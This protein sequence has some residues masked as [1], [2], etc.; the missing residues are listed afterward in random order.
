MASPH[1][2]RP[3]R[4]IVVDDVFSGR[5]QSQGYP[6]RYLVIGVGSSLSD[7]GFGRSGAN[8]MIDRVLSAVEMLE[9]QGWE[10]VNVDQGGTIACLR[11]R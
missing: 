5:F 10:L 1:P 3:P 4:L 6:F 7:V 11:R 9:A 8:N 2:P